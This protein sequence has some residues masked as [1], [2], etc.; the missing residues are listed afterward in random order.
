MRRQ[1]GDQSRV[2]QGAYPI[3][4][5]SGRDLP[6]GAHFAGYV[7]VSATPTLRSASRQAS[8]LPRAASSLRHGLP[9]TTA[10]EDRRLSSRPKHLETWR[11]QA[12][13]VD[14]DSDP[15]PRFV[16]AL[17]GARARRR[18][19]SDPHGRADER[20]RSAFHA[21]DRRADPAAAPAPH[22]RPR[23]AQRGARRGASPTGS[24]ASASATAR[25]RS[26]RA[27]AATRCST[28]ACREGR[29][30]TSPTPRRE[31]P[32]AAQG[33][34]DTLDAAARPIIDSPAGLVHP[35]GPWQRP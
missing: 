7:R 35:R 26:S 33:I 1:A 16:E 22:D 19:G 31:R 5:R 25:A 21:G 17:P 24:P 8:A 2:V 13:E 27:P 15:I 32:Q 12:R 28:P 3:V 23:D 29:S 34:R 30:N 6:S 11:A 20:A 9:A 14:L 10:V 18:A 4:F